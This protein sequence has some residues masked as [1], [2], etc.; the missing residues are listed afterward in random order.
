MPQYFLSIIQGNQL[1]HPSNLLT[2][3]L[4]Q[5]VKMEPLLIDC[6][7]YMNSYLIK[8]YGFDYK[9]YS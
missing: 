1:F 6:L 8:L 9:T 5:T 2:D 3:Y 4:K 7:S